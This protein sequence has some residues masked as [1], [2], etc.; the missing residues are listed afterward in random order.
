MTARKLKGAP[1]GYILIDVTKYAKRRK[2]KT[3]AGV[4]KSGPRKRKAKALYCVLCGLN[5]PPGELLRHKE[6]A[7]GEEIVPRV[8]Q[9]AEPK[10]QWINIV[11]GGLPGLGK[12]K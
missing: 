8:T 7:H 11:Q 9:T 12:R 2:Q 1:E 6:F 10:I 5:I 4:K 3:I